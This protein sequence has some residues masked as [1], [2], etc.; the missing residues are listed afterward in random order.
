MLISFMHSCFSR[1]CNY[2]GM[3]SAFGCPTSS[4]ARGLHCHVRLICCV[5]YL[6]HACSSWWCQLPTMKMKQEG[7]IDTIGG[8]MYELEIQKK[9][10]WTISMQS[11]PMIM[12]SLYQ[13][14][15]NWNF[16]DMLTKILI[17][18][19][20]YCIWTTCNCLFLGSCLSWVNWAVDCFCQ[21]VL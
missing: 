19:T 21:G 3:K 10:S 13:L 7:L 5:L 18:L 20:S 16:K 6:L 8:R 9:P 14:I 4:F 1:V 2:T 12:M 15:S 11:W 17:I